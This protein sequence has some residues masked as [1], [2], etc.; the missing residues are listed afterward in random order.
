M[1][2]TPISRYERD[3]QKSGFA[4]DAAQRQAIERLQILFDELVALQH[5]RVPLWQR[6]FAFGKTPSAPK[7]VY[8]WGGVGRGKTYIM[9]VFFETLPFPQ[10]MRVHFHRF[11][12][13]VHSELTRFKGEKNPLEKVADVLAGEARVICFD[14]FFVSDITDA[15][16]LGNLLD[17]L[18]ARGVTL[19]ATSNIEPDGLYKD[20]LQRVRFLPAIALLNSHTD[21]LNVDGGTDYRLRTLVKADLFHSPLGDEAEQAL[22]NCFHRLVPERGA[23]QQNVPLEVENRT[24]CAR[25]EADD[26]AWFDF[27]ALCDGPRSQNDYIVLAKEFHAI[28]VSNVPQFVGRNDDQA[29]RFIYM[30]D[31][32]YD[33]RVKLVLSAACPVTELYK[34][35]RLEFEFQRTVSRLLEMQSEEYLAQPHRP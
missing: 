21:V 10:K 4:A 1:I 11:M 3:L 27:A 31:E 32:F 7:G 33:R 6:L 24:I 35:G 12:R 26:V 2:D 25:Y 34:E 18:F 14:E 29:R 28:L 5:R 23:I 15:M 22:K 20:G 19:V 13:R 16:I 17:A 9:D 8:M 30:V